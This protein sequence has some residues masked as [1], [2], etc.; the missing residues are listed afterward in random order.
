MARVSEDCLFTVTT[1]SWPAP[2]PRFVSNQAYLGSC[3]M[4]SW[5][6]QFRQ[7]RGKVTENMNEMSQ[8]IIQNLYASMPDRIA[9]CISTR[10]GSTG[11]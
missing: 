4:A 2:I 9:L 5:A 3:G 6:S 8:D 7:I 1:L 10:G 11:Y